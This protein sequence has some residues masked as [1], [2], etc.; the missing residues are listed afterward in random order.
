MDFGQVE[1]C[2]L[3]SVEEQT[4]AARIDFVGGDALEDL[5]YG[6]LDGGAI[7]GQSEV[8]CGGATAALC[9]IGDGFTA[10]V[11]AVTEL[12]LAQAWAGAAVAIGE[13][14]AALVLFQCF[15]GVCIGSSPTGTFCVKSSKEMR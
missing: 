5:A 13:D 4:G 6:D 10:G 7:L 8:E 12:S 1:A 2:D 9:W 3:E 15:D 14:V 11:V